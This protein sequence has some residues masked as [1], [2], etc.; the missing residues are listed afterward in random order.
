[1]S[2]NKPF[3]E[4]LKLSMV[5]I[6]PEPELTILSTVPVESVSELEKLTKSPLE[7]YVALFAMLTKRAEDDLFAAVIVA[8]IVRPSAE[9][10]VMLVDASRDIASKNLLKSSESS[11]MWAEPSEPETSVVPKSTAFVVEPEPIKMLEVNV[12]ET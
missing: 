2:I 12:S 4:A 6:L 9:S 8:A 7:L 3:P 10:A 1:M 11:A 5:A